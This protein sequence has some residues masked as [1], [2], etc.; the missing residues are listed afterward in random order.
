[1]GVK[2][3]HG[4]IVAQIYISKSDWEDR[5]AT[6]NAIS[7]IKIEKIHHE[8]FD[9]STDV[10]GKVKDPSTGGH[11]TSYLMTSTHSLALNGSTWSR[12]K[13]NKVREY[14]RRSFKS[15]GTR[16]FPKQPGDY[17][18]KDSDRIRVTLD[19]QAVNKIIYPTDESIPSSELRYQIKGAIEFQ[20]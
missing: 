20:R 16:N 10:T 6:E 18:Q 12:T 19:C 8:Y 9:V 17:G 14:N 5:T 2:R 11:N 15:R 7:D 1:M 3:T 4:H 13:E